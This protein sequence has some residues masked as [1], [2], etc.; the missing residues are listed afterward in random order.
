MMQP[1][2][3]TNFG[4][5][6]HKMQQHYAA[7]EGGMTNDELVNP[8]YWANV[9]PRMRPGDTIMCVAQDYSYSALLQVTYAAGQQVRVKLIWRAELD[10]VDP[11]ATDDPASP[12]FVDLRGQ[13]KWC[14]VERATANVI[15]AGIPTRLEAEKELVDYLKALAA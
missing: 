7:P 15:K 11:N 5:I 3:P 9:A 1:L 8:A 13:K 14:I 12:F 6:Q 10:H 4:L 2:N